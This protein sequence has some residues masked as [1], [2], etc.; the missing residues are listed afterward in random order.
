[1]RDLPRND[2]RS[3]PLKTHY[4]AVVTTLRLKAEWN[5]RVPIHK[6]ES[7][8]DESNLLTQKHQNQHMA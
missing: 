2:I 4:H 5:A 6:L 3:M 1:M 8:K 7:L